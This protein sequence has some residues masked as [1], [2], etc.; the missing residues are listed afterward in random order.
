MGSHQNAISAKLHPDLLRLYIRNH[1]ISYAY[2]GLVFLAFLAAKIY[3]Y[4]LVLD[5]QEIL[6][7]AAFL[8]LSGFCL[9]QLKRFYADY[10]KGAADEQKTPSNVMNIML[11]RG[12]Y[13]VSWL[14]FLFFPLEVEYFFRH[15]LAYGFIFCAIAIY[16]SASSSFL[17]L[18][19][20]DIGILVLTSAAIGVVNINLPETSYAL[21]F[22][23]TFAGSC[24]F[25]ALR[26]NKA[27]RKFVRNEYALKEAIVEA[28]R[29]TQAKAEFL[30][31]ISHEVRT[32]MT[33]ISG[34]VDFLGE[35]QLTAEQQGYL[36]TIRQCSSTLMN[37]L[38]DVLDI[39][40][41]EAGQLSITPIDFDF[42]TML[43]GIEKTYENLAHQKNISFAVYVDQNVPRYIHADPNRIQQVI[44]NLANNA[45]K[46]TDHG[47][48]TVKV[49]FDEMISVVVEDTGI[50]VSEEH[51][52]RLFKKFSQVDGS[53]SRKYGGTGLGLF[54]S[55]SLIV[56]MKGEV[57]FSSVEGQGSTFWFKVPYKP[58]SASL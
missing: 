37:T 55:Q 41:M 54:I 58:A 7:C 26:N 19:I 40:K 6:S 15:L 14:F 4:G 27:A 23:V 50:G 8:V 21:A 18:L 17:P 36:A 51:Q 30:A 10:L 9:F 45:V 25:V 2:H 42:H 13:I 34:M 52:K 5:F 20:F 53:I 49:H 31:V 1:Q 39:S 12:V 29:V 46:F 28:D 38:N 44:L 11:W 33:G 47:G 35:T 22:V 57:G 48:V 43:N 3:I 24:L 32:P 16:A 56:S